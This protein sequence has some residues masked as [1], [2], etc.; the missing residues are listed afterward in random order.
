MS[1]SQIEQLAELVNRS[2]IRRIKVVAWRDLD[3]PEAGGSELHAGEVLRRWA[4]AGLDITQR[5]SAVSG[6]PHE[7]VR[8]GYRVVRR[9]GRYRIFAEVVREGFR[10]SE[11]T[12]DAVVEIWNGM[13]F[14]SP[15]WF[16]GPRTVW[17]HH[18]HGEMWQMT[19]P[20]LLGRIGWFIEHRLAP[21]FYRRSVI[22]TL[23]A[24]S[25]QEIHERL[26]LSRTT[27]IPPGISNFYR[28]G[29]VK[30]IEPTVVAVGRL[31][32][33]KRFDLLIREFVATRV[34]SP[35]ARLIIAGEGYLRGELEQLID[36]L[37]AGDFISLVG[38]ISDEEL[39]RLYQS[40]WVVASA[41]LREGWGMSLTEAAACGTPCVA[42]DIAGHRDSVSVN[43]SGLLVPD[44]S[45]GQT[46]AHVLLDA[47]LRQR[48][49]D[50]AVA[51]AS[52]LSWDHT[53]KRLFE[54]LDRS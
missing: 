12:Y 10:R 19:L 31:V 46:I 2:R 43:R 42:T 13:P 6:Q 26:H 40:A 51:Y 4:Q 48:L 17:L 20:G 39:L 53:A 47:E 52:E 14:F 32:P 38:R 33:V 7:T 54:L 41:S 9:D 1:T 35:N 49:S 22:A 5:T 28:I 27:V 50:G 45:I 30:T 16:R 3:D 24:S 36:E 21:L 23:S 11:P 8:D 34:L 18:V 29:G 37:D 15:V 25:E 44:S